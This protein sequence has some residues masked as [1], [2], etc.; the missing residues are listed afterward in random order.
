MEIVSR[1]SKLLAAERSPEQNGR[2]A[3]RLKQDGADI[4]GVSVG[5][6]SAG[7]HEP[8]HSRQPPRPR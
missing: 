5:P 6:R 7:A 8:E 1:P 3:V 2:G 4:P